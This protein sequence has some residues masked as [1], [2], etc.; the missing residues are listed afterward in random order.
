MLWFPVYLR[1]E[2]LHLKICIICSLAFKTRTSPQV[3]DKDSL[4][5]IE[6]DSSQQQD[7][8]ENF[9]GLAIGEGK[10]RGVVSHF[11]IDYHLVNQKPRKE[12]FP[13]KNVSYCNLVKLFCLNSGDPSQTSDPLFS[14]TQNSPLPSKDTGAA[15]IAAFPTLSHSLSSYEQNVIQQTQGVVEYRPC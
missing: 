5:N 13:K 6:S 1:F 4:N 12:S 14:S 9:N 10:R 2:I 7:I 11:C 8:L 15:N 3:K